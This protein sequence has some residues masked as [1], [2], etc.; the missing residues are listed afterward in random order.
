MSTATQPSYSQ[1][2]YLILER[3]ANHKS[4]YVN[5]S[6]LAMS[7][8]SRRHNL[9]TLNIASELRFQLKG[10]SCE[11]YMSD[12]RVKVSQTGLYTY[13][14]VVAVCGEIQFD[15]EHHDTLVNPSLLV[16]VLSPS[17]EAYDRGQKF[18]HYRRLPSLQEYLLIAQ[19]RACVEMYTR[20]GEIWVLSE[21]NDLNESVSLVSINCELSL[22]EIYDKV[23][24][25]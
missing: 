6:I 14:D 19:E 13:P 1:E 18:G 16:E 23:Q 5:G 4:E 12:M 3:Q 11:A 17:T 9:I 25:D 22:H 20:Q 8:A 7:G 10:R 2:E 24:F 21:T 15:D